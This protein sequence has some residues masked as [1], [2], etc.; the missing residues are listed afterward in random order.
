MLTHR[1]DTKNSPT[2]TR[3]FC[4]LVSHSYCTSPHPNA[5]RGKTDDLNRR[6]Y[7]SV[8]ITANFFKTK[9]DTFHYF[10][11]LVFAI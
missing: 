4:V 1:P 6:R 3:A 11:P 7:I 9:I 5:S 10:L 8:M 2:T